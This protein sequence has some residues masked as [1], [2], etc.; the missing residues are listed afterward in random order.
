M[1]DNHHHVDLNVLS[2][3][4]VLGM[5]RVVIKNAAILV[6]VL[7]ELELYVTYLI[8]DLYAV[9]RKDIQAMRS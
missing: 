1:L 2:I 3:L 4:I 7:V 6:W 5:K 9:A 8:I